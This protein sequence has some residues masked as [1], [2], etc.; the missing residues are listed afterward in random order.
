MLF[1]KI[2]KS[3]SYCVHAIKIDDNT[4]ACKRKGPVPVDGSCRCF[5]YDPFKRIPEGVE[6]ELPE[7]DEEADYSL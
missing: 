5:R 7:Q 1:R 4:M 6:L 3:C 2:E